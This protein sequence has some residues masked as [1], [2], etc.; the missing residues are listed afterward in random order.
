MEFLSFN[1]PDFLSVDGL[2]SLRRSTSYLNLQNHGLMANNF[3][4]DNSSNCQ[5]SNDAREVSD[6]SSCLTE[7]ESDDGSQ[8][9][10]KRIKCDSSISSLHSVSFESMEDHEPSVKILNNMANAAC[11]AMEICT[12]NIGISNNN[13]NSSAAIGKQPVY[14]GSYVPGTAT[15]RGKYKCK[16]CGAFKTNHVCTVIAETILMCSQSTGMD[17]VMVV[18]ID[19]S[20]VIADKTLPIRK[21]QG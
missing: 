19:N 17:P 12:K 11:S 6:G 7:T 9:Q 20:L 2:L 1:H 18:V 16:H 15:N 13:D 21:W 14:V 3:C 4:S 5:L 10:S 8:V